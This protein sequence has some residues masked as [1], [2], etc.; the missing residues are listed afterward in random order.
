MSQTISA[1]KLV[2]FVQSSADKGDFPA[3][4]KAFDDNCGLLKSSKEVA[5]AFVLLLAADSRMP[6][7]RDEL[8]KIIADWSDDSLLVYSCCLQLLS[9][10]D[11][12]AACDTIPANDPTV[13]VVPALE[14][15]IEGLS[16][17]ERM[18]PQRGGVFWNLLANAYRLAGPSF[19]KKA[20]V[21]YEQALKIEARPNFR[22][23]LGLFFKNR[24]RWEEGL[25]VFQKLVDEGASGQAELWNL[26]ICA[27]ALRQGDK[28]LWAWDRIGLKMEL[29][30]DGL[31]HVPGLGMSK[32]LLSSGS[33]AEVAHLRRY[34]QVWVEPLSPCHGIVLNAT[35]HD[36]GADMGDT[37]LWDGQP[38]GQWERDGVTGP[39]FA[40]LGTLS[41]GQWRTF[42]FLAR[43]SPSQSIES[44]G[45]AMPNRSRIFVFQEE[46]VDY[47]PTCASA[48]CQG[49]SD[50]S[51][52]SI[53]VY[54]KLVV[55]PKTSLEDLKQ[56]LS[57]ALKEQ[58][59]LQMAV[60]SLFHSLGE[61]SEAAEH[62][63]LWD[64]LEDLS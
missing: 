31:P 6:N 38:V 41:K 35:F 64:C 26:A 54:G 39:V 17:A 25:D 47:C 43:R 23:D 1:S 28:A 58:P 33:I 30:S 40:G 21:A 59:T 57:G 49:Q 36:V 15:A 62:E 22:F 13:V 14:R 18:D 56:V 8:E 61:E 60:P 16:D 20:L 12:R 2:D 42:R 7:K 45:R 34:E 50:H 48:T 9:L 3:A 37:V 53:V 32:V 44:I 24:A 4:W 10:V 52:E 55:C 63:K 27:T 11:G 46:A 51:T 5:W 29:D 19:D